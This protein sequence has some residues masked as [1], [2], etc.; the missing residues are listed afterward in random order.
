MDSLLLA[1]PADARVPVRGLW[2]ASLALASACAAGFWLFARGFLLTRMVLT[3]ATLPSELPF[4]NGAEAAG[5]DGWMPPQFERA[6]VLVVDAMRVDFAT[7]VPELNR[8][9]G[10][11]P[12]PY[13]NKLPVIAELSTQRPDQTKLFRFRADPPTTTL[14][15]LKGLTTGQLPTFVDA[16][17]NF[18]GSAIDEDNWLRALRR[19]GRNLVFLGDDTWTSLFPRELQDTQDQ[20]NNGTYWDADGGWVRARAFP[21]LN[22]WDLE[23]VDDGVLSRL[24]QLLLPPTA[25][26]DDRRAQWRELVQQAHMW[27]SADFGADGMGSARV[28]AAALHREWDTIIAHG[29]GV[30]HCGHRFGP[31]HPAMERKLGQM[32]RAIELIVDAIDGDSRRTALFVLGDHGMDATGDHGGDSPREVDAGLWIY[33]NTPW[34]TA[35]GDARADRVLAHAEKALGDIDVDDDLR[36]GW[37]DNTHISDEYLHVAAPKMRS[38]TQVDLAPTLALALGLPVPFNSL[39]ATMPEVF[40]SGSSADG[41]WGLLR[42]LRLSA[43]QLLRYA[44]TYAAA[45]GSG[46]AD[47][48]LKSWHAA[49]DRAEA[50][51]HALP[52]PGRDKEAEERVAGAYLAFARQVLGALRRE[53]AQFDAIRMITGLAVLALALLAMVTLAARGGRFG[54]QAVWPCI[55]TGMAGA[56]VTRALGSVLAGRGATQ[57]TTLEAAAAG[58]AGGSLV[59]L[60]A[61]QAPKIRLGWRPST[62]AILNGVAMV[63]VLCHCLAFASNSLTVSEDRVVLYTAQT[64]TLAAGAVGM[65][66]VHTAAGQRAMLCAGVILVLNRAAAVS[67]VCREEQMPHCTPTFYGRA[68]A[69]I[70]TLP[71]AAANVLCAW[72]VP[73]AIARELRRSRSDGAL[74]ARLWVGVGMR[75]SMAMTAVHWL[76]DALDG[77]DQAASDWGDVRLALARMAIGVAVGGGLVAWNASPLCLDAVIPPRTT[78]GTA[79]TLLGTGNV[80]GAAYLVFASAIFCVL[81]A[82]QQP[83]GGLA[84]SAQLLATLAATELFASLRATLNSESIYPAL[85]ALTAQ[86]SFLG[87]FAT[88]HQFTLASVQWSTAFFVV[89]QMRMAVCGATVALNTMG[90][91][92]LGAL[93]LPLPVLWNVSLHSPGLRS[94]PLRVTA[95][96][97]AYGAYHMAVA[98]TSALCA[99]WL[100]RHLMVWKIFAP[101]FMFAAPVALVSAAL[102]LL[103]AGLATARVVREALAISRKTE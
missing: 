75:V 19:Q 83:M 85:A 74:L 84:L 41:E 58:L 16:G 4:G 61:T 90:A 91:F 29:L 15:R 96:A 77:R 99:A 68:G 64:L 47:G 43:A 95:A 22:V 101:R 44:D 2:V 23:T 98:L 36:T 10:E 89:R 67:T 78:R 8:T 53:W 92:I 49:F 66:H 34:H 72:I 102:A 28:D 60:A 27:D 6:I 9:D 24:P 87:Y 62:A 82:V 40:A 31:D 38:V 7:W 30:D 13:H 42:A 88:G 39:G 1:R 80:L 21:S 81:Y 17:S 97:A 25:D 18:A 79:L 73:S 94:A 37:W 54:A 71:L 65:A 35:D 46:F 103:A 33:A 76:L 48:A 50:A 100:R 20:E 45:G 86:L 55:G 51:R 59:A 56:M 12:K 32:N 5:P 57:A 70:S 93:C 63:L 69:S 3:D 11:Q 26:A 52:A 14:Q